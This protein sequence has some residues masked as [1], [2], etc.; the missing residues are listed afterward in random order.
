MQDTLKQDGYQVHCSA[1]F[2]LSLLVTVVTLAFSKPFDFQTSE[3]AAHRRSRHG[4]GCPGLVQ[5]LTGRHQASAWRSAQSLFRPHL[6]LPLHS[7]S[8]CRS[9]AGSED[10]TCT[11]SM[12]L[13]DLARCQVANHQ[14]TL[15]TCSLERI[16]EHVAE[17]ES[18]IAS[19]IIADCSHPS[20]T[21]F[22]I[23]SDSISCSIPIPR[24]H[25]KQTHLTLS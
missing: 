9:A 6:P 17:E 13:G 24:C 12:L 10:S 23:W 25:G 22:V 4:L 19:T 3:P 11:N 18:A 1:A 14:S 7:A 2:E 21:C 15:L 8:P 5:L 16:T 20:A